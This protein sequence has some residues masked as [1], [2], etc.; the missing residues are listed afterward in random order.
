MTMPVWLAIG[1][2]SGQADPAAVEQVGR[3]DRAIDTPQLAPLRR[4]VPAAPP[5]VRGETPQVTNG[6]RN[7]DAPDSG[8]T[9]AQG[10]NVRADAVE[11]DDRCDPQHPQ[12]GADCDGVIETRS[13]EFQSPDVQPLSPEQRLL[14]AQKGLDGAALNIDTATRRLANG[15]VDASNVGLAASSIGALQGQPEDKKDDLSAQQN[16]IVSAVVG[17]V[18]TGSQ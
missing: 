13:A 7:A 18:Q 10:R 3:A 6:R 11:G 16:A 5:V 1:L 4:E 14:L 8:S 17:I 15:E 12:K 9:R 2:L